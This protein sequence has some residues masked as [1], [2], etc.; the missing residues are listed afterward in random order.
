MLPE[1]IIE[2]TR[3]L[4]SVTGASPAD[5]Q[6]RPLGVG[7]NN[8]VFLV[9]S[10]AGRCVAKWYFNEAGTRDR[11]RC[12]Y[13][14]LTRVWHGGIRNVPRPIA[15]DAR[16][17]LAL[18]EFLPGRRIAAQDI[19]RGL[20]EQAARFYASLNAAALRT[21]AK[22]LENASDA[23]FTV[24]DH[25][26]SV[27]RR[28]Q[29]LSAI[30]PLSAIDHSAASFVKELAEAWNAIKAALIASIRY[31]Q[32]PLCDDWC[33]I[34]PSDFGFHNAILRDSGEL[35]FVDFEYAGWD[36]P[37]KLTGD[38]FS[39]PE[40]PVPAAHLEHF[41]TAAFEPFSARAELVA[42]VTRLM[43][44]SKIRWCCIM[45]NDFLPEVAGRRQFA[46]PAAAMEA[47]KE[48]QLSKVRTLFAVTS[49]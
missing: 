19:D 12:E 3:R 35:C 27:D 30:D 22:D 9:E 14:F 40:I 49:Y 39:H 33:S 7:G 48:R 18:Y 25:I 2:A 6:F 13:E 36:D 11:M 1:A 38:F 29:R 42:R 17:H 16:H 32:R 23:C 43:A 45:L 28:I 44:V 47:R 8:R 26:R 4:V 34:S 46:D 21:A 41:M 15:R 24:E 5:L 10:E 31:A 20:V 37:A